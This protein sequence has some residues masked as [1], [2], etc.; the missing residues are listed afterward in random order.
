MKLKTALLAAILF[1]SPAFAADCAT[2]LMATGLPGLAAKTICTSTGAKTVDSLTATSGDITLTA[3]AVVQTRIISIPAFTGV[4]GATSSVGWIVAASDK[5]LATLAASATADTLVIPIVG[6]GIGDT[7]TAFKITGQID[8]AGNTAT[9]DA[10]LRK[11][12]PAVAGTADAS[13]GAITQVSVTADTLVAS[14]KTLAAAEV[15]ASGESLYLLVT[16]TTAGT[17]DIEVSSVEL[18]VLTGN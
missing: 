9:L 3:G 5:G 15:I 14:S 12:T 11:V 13:I 8:S 18:T 1:T 16:G 7:V 17:T 6:L 4:R 10:D 2:E